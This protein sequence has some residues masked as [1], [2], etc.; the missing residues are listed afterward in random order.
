VVD[1]AG[2]SARHASP[3]LG[4]LRSLLVVSFLFSVIGD[5]SVTVGGLTMPI[6]S[7]SR[8]RRS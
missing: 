3:P 4:D 8:L 6:L 2:E 5:S 1:V 7:C